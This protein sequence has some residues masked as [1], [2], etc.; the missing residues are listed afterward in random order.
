LVFITNSESWNSKGRWQQRP[1]F[2]E[3]VGVGANPFLKPSSQALGEERRARSFLSNSEAVQGHKYGSHQMTDKFAFLHIYKCGGTTVRLQTN[4]GEARLTKMKDREFVTV[5]RD[6]V[7]H[8]LSGWAECGLRN[9]KANGMQI[10]ELEGISYDARVRDFLTTVQKAATKPKK[11]SCAAHSFPQANFIVHRD[12]EV[13]DN[14]KVIGDLHE[15]AGVLELVGFPYDHSKK[16]GRDAS[17][18]MIKT[19]YYPSRKDLISKATMLEICQFVAIDYFLFDFEPP[20]ACRGLQIQGG[21]LDF[22]DGRSTEQN[23]ANG[24]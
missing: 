9:A 24:G 20:E 4:R 8:F 16:I 7:D 12:G 18:E 17:A 1:L 21:P 22:S 23:Q 13:L 5:V 10:P 11:F 19:K 3:N 6:P 2:S 14:L 15:V